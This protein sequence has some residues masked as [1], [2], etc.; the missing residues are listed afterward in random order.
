MSV[1]NTVEAELRRGEQARADGNEG[2]ARVSAR[3]AAGSLLRDYLEA[4]GE[5]TVGLSSYDLIE[6]AHASN[7][8]SPDTVDLLS[9]F[10][11]RVEEGGNF[12]ADIDLLADVVTL[13]NRLG[14][15]PHA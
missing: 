10:L 3:R 1:W 14:I 12:P 8:F 6:I 7:A 11:R 5:S 2:Q 13:A 4:H 9:H 15:E